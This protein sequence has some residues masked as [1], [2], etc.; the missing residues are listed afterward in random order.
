MKIVLIASS[1]YAI[2]IFV[3][4]FSLAR[5]MSVLFYKL[6]LWYWPDNVDEPL[7]SINN[8]LIIAGIFSI[9]GGIMSVCMNK[10]KIK[11]PHCSGQKNVQND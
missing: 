9:A 2:L 8:A 4:F 10:S 11:K 7:I 6:R 1:I 5:G 3:L